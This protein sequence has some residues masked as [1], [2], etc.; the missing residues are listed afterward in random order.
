MVA[1]SVD[2]SRASRTKA[3]DAG[4][5]ALSLSKPLAHTHHAD[6]RSSAL[7]GTTGLEAL[8]LRPPCYFETNSR[9][10]PTRLDEASRI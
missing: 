9:P 1:E 5:P 10:T 2:K 7:A 4:G 3:V 6:T 8:G